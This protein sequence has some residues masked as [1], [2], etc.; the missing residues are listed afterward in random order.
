MPAIHDYFFIYFKTTSAVLLVDSL[1]PI[2][3]NQIDC[4]G[5]QLNLAVAQHVN[6]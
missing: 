6:P 2:S 3:E 5:L 4:A 1:Y